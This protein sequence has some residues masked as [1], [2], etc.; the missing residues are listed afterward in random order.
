MVGGE[1]K[2]VNHNMSLLLIKLVDKITILLD[3]IFEKAI[4]KDKIHQHILPNKFVIKRYF[5]L[6]DKIFI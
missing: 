1:I 4:I 3:F 5:F 6:I 2:F